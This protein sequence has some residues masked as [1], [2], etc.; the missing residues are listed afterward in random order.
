MI[1]IFTRSHD[2]MMLIQLKGNFGFEG[3]TRAFQDDFRSEL[4]SHGWQYNRLSFPSQNAILILRVIMLN[5]CLLGAFDVM[6]EGRRLHIS[7]RSVQSLFAYLVLNNGIPHRRE[8]LAK[9]LWPD[10]VETTARE[11]LR[12]TLWRIRKAFPKHLSSVYLSTDDFTIAFE[13]SAKCWVDVATL[14]DADTCKGANDL[15]EN[16]SVYQGELLPGF[17]DEW[18]ILEREYLNFVFEH[19]MAR[20]MSM[21]KTEKRWLDILDWGERWIAFGQRPE[22]AYRALM[23]AHMKKGEMSKVGEA[24]T[25][26]V[27]SLNEIGLEPSEQTRI[28][29][30]RLKG[31]KPL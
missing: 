30:E 7:G 17:D 4:G 20:L 18:V 26:C 14:K 29:Y 27:R 1:T 3:Q 5:I 23:L 10:S 28:L 11:N 19:N 21:L 25:R 6:H 31:G 24:Y 2:S 22:P 8:K 16:L 13:Y 15:I 12:H 9:M